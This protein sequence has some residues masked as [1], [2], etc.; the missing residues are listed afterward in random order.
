LAGKEV[1]RRKNPTAF[2]V[3]L[4]RKGTIPLI[5][6]GNARLGFPDFW[7][8]LKYS[9]G[10]DK[11]KAH[12]VKINVVLMTVLAVVLSFAAVNAGADPKP[13]VVFN[14][15]TSVHDASA[16]DAYFTAVAKQ[17][18]LNVIDTNLT[19]A[20][21]QQK[22]M[23]LL[24]GGVACDIHT[25]WWSGIKTVQWASAGLWK[26][27]SADWKKMGLAGVYPKYVT[28][29]C[30]YNGKQWQFPIGY[31]T[32]GV[33]YNKHIFDKLG[34]KEPS[35]W[36]E[37]LDVCEKIKKSGVTPLAWGAAEQ[38]GHMQQWWDVVIYNSIGD[39]LYQDLMQ[40]KIRWDN[41]QVMKAHT[42]MASLLVK[43][44]FM[45]GV[46][47]F[48]R[49]EA[50]NYL[51]NGKAA[52][53]LDGDYML[54]GYEL[55]GFKEGADLGW[56]PVPAVYPNIKPGIVAGFDMIAIPANAPHPEAA[57]KL[58]Q[59]W[60]SKEGDAQWGLVKRS[61]PTNRDAIP[62]FMSKAGPIMQRIA[63]TLQDMTFVMESQNVLPNDLQEVVYTARQ[64]IVSYPD[65]VDEIVKQ[66]AEKA[67]QWYSANKNK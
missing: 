11:M 21:Y 39:N 2:N 26:D 44:Y 32:S 35:T 25:G 6:R 7:G 42:E 54:V 23:Q 56:F 47:S 67:A 57:K 16:K 34:L 58:A 48:S 43:G 3:R 13:V 1:G 15:W 66:M 33:F 62:E 60:T 53:E 19:E 36:T 17:T 37:F 59:F 46:L 9:I 49:D 29:N 12:H 30:T 64:Q 41:D 52:M 61:V 65:R 31:C 22:V 20:F 5:R 63:K 40:G 28:S 51:V 50:M 4:G 55:K 18:G 27:V 10:G 8:G 14:H 45:S 38:L 24:V